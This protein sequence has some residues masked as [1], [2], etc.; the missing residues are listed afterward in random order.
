MANELYRSPN[1]RIFGVVT[2]LAE[3]TNLSAPMLR[4]IVF[5]LVIFSGVV[6]GVILYLIAALLIP[7]RPEVDTASFYQERQQSRANSAAEEA[8]LR[9][10]YQ[11]L[12]KRIE[13][14]ESEILNKERDWEKRFKESGG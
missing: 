6:P 13:E 10:E 5:I 9:A 11:R 12:K 14:L 8:R 7:M 3:R 2:G 4:L 1:G